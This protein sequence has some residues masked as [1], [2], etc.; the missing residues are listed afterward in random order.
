[1]TGKQLRGIIKAR[2]DM[3]RT[4]GR[5]ETHTQKQN[6]TSTVLMET[7]PEMRSDPFSHKFCLD[8][9]VI[10]VNLN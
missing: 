3:R 8:F 9:N 6:L 1:M 10:C 4:G 7:R 2:P 5:H